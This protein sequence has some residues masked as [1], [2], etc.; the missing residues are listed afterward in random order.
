MGE[1]VRRS[2]PY[3][4]SILSLSH[5]RGFDLLGHAQRRVCPTTLRYLLNSRF[6]QI[7]RCKNRKIEPGIED[8]R[9]TINDP[10][11]GQAAQTL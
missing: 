2:H 11:L 8:P 9:N 1:R 4:T 3:I 5:T 6:G 10:R 7:G